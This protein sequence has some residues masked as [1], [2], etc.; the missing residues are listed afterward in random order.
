MSPESAW[1]MF[2]FRDGRQLLP[3]RTLVR[4]AAEAIRAAAAHPALNELT[5]ALLL[6]GQLECSLVDAASDEASRVATVTDTLA[7]A[8]IEREIRSS[9]GAVSASSADLLALLAL[10]PEHPPAEL[11]TSPPE[12]FAYYALHP[13]DF[14]D[15]AS[16]V[17]LGSSVVG[18]IGIRSIGVT[19]SALVLAGLRRNG[20]RAE[21]F[22][23]RPNGH[24]YDRLTEFSPAQIARIEA[25][26]SASADFLIVDEGPGMSGSSFLSV[27]DAL[28]QHGVSRERIAFLGSRIPDPD[29][30]RATDG[31]R[32]WR[33]FRSYVAHKNSRLPSDANIYV[34][35]GD[36]RP[37]GFENEGLWP[38]SW[39]QMERLKFLSTDRRFL[40]KFEGFGNLGQVVYDRALCSAEAGFG[41]A[42]MDFTQG[43]VVYSMLQ[44]RPLSADRLTP[45]LLDRMADYCAFR[46]AEFASEQGQNAAELETMLR[47]NTSVALGCDVSFDAGTLHAAR[48]VIVDGRMLPHEWVQTKDSYIK[49]DGNSHGDDHFFPGPADI[50]WDL[51]GAIVEWAMPTDAAERFLSRYRLAT[52]DDPRQRLSHFLLAYTVFR[53][54]YCAM[55]AEAVRGSGEEHRLTAD[56]DRYQILAD[57]LLHSAANLRDQRGLIEAPSFAAGEMRSLEPSHTAVRPD[58]LQP[59]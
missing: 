26:R 46:V 37:F 45:A 51:A 27:G 9:P 56:R 8:F 30:L 20:L 44:G 28:V 53:L 18:V 4:D 57:K 29:A 40:F 41:P 17:P 49:V 47:F 35:G 25:L 33:S 13:M 50:A 12:G 36:W 38:A 55:A 11:K 31:G 6:A 10:L 5:N 22:T 3:G 58:P 52:G 34:G 15:L 14:A 23:V 39:T 32:R 1:N 42:A 43:F 48:P 24:P 7:S 19:L 16:R 54:G 21:R 59:V 2:V